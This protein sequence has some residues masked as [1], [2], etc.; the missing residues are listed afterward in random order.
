[1]PY[2]FPNVHL[3]LLMN[4][5]KLSNEFARTFFDGRV[6]EDSRDTAEVRVE[7]N[8]GEK[9]ISVTR[10]FFE[11]EALRELQI[12]EGSSPIALDGFHLGTEPQ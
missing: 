12:L 1:M 6:D 2:Q 11:V 3:N 9:K 4:T 10:N 7:F 8:V 5:H